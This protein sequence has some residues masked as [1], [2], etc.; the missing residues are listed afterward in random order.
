MPSPLKILVCGINFPHLVQIQLYRLQRNARVQNQQPDDTTAA[1][2]QK[3]AKVT[4]LYIYRTYSNRRYDPM[5][6]IHLSETDN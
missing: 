5:A 1:T 6:V 2:A 4:A 3:K